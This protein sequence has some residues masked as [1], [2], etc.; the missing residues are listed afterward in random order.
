MAN[1]DFV[2]NDYI[3]KR[4]STRANLMYLLLF[5]VV[6]AGIGATF[7]VIKMRQ[8]D[9]NDQLAAIDV[10]LEQAQAKFVLLEKLQAK[11][12]EMMKT[13][14][15]TAELFENVPRSVVLAC[16]TN[17]LP[18]GVSLQDLKL[19]QKVRKTAPAAAKGSTQYSKAANAN[20][21]PVSMEQM[22]ETY[23][24]IKGVAPSDI[25]VASYISQLS[26]SI[27]LERTSLV[28][29]KE[30]EIDDAKFREFKLTTKIKP[31][32]QLTKEDIE[33][34]STEGKATA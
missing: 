13:A 32:L 19:F 31:G 24:E 7:F 5:I 11:G 18:K 28:E 33:S 21:K 1:I 4:D 6:M 20:Q 23:I 8:K 25:E 14:S 17:N 16:L 12:T 2:P 10:Q 26:S 15:M 30:F 34:L 29:S 3:Q 27:L 22:L 9:I